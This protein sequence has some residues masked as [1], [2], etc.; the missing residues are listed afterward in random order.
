MHSDVATNLENMK[1]LEFMKQTDGDGIQK[2]LTLP[3]GM[4]AL[5]LW[6]MIFPP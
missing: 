3:L 2:D 5:W 4:A 1:L 6:T